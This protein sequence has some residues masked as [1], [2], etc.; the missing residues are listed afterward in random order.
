VGRS[1]KDTTSRIG[2]GAATG[3]L[4]RELVPDPACDYQPTGNPKALNRKS[5][6]PMQV[7]SYSDVL[8]HY[9]VVLQE[10]NLRPLAP[11]STAA[12]VAALELFA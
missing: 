9:S 4:L 2:A 1:N 7:Q 3:E 6:N 12:L 11:R 5:P 8:R 10:L